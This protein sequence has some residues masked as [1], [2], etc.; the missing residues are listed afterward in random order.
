MNFTE[1]G[2]EHSEVIMLL[3]G[4]GLSWWNYREEAQLLQDRFRV[5]L[6]VLDG[7]AGSDS[8]FVT[9][10]SCAQHIIDHIDRHFGGSVLFI[11]GLSLGGQVL[12]E[13]LSRRKDI[14]RYA[15]IESAAII[16]APV[17]GR[18]VAPSF[19]ASYGL[20]EQRW[21]SKLQFKSL[22][23]KPELFE[24]YYADTCRI[25][26]EDMIAFTRESCFFK[27]RESLKETA[28]KVRIFVGGRESRRMKRSAE[29]L[30]GLIPDSGRE[31]LS[32]LHHGEFSVNHA[33]QYVSRLCRFIGR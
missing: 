26:R 13:M 12:V 14:C 9:I 29:R 22:H 28:A 2:K 5:V 20:I 11:G 32:G 21:F 10:E 27:A 15:F 8:S 4:G 30:Q 3:H 1:F 7:H 16:P 31:I 24:D 18:L 6:P 17:T 25:S 23:M 33:G 19:G